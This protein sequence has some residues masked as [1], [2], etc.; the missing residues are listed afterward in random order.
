M[1]SK[2]LTRYQL[3]YAKAVFSRA[4]K[5]ESMYLS[6]Y[7]LVCTSISIRR[8]T[9][10]APGIAKNTHSKCL[11]LKPLFDP[12]NEFTFNDTRYSCIF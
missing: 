8:P 10:K 5:K 3:C 11:A 9:T 1:M 2:D 12:L 6:M 7:Y 4:V